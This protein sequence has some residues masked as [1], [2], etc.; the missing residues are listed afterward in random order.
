MP[1]EAQVGDAAFAVERELHA[2]LVAAERVVV[3][4][5]EVRRLQLRR[6][7]RPVVGPLVV[8]EDLLAVEVVHRDYTLV[9][10]LAKT[11]A[12]PAPTRPLKCGEGR[13]RDGPRRFAAVSARVP[14]SKSMGGRSDGE[15][16]QARP[17]PN[18]DGC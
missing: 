7:R 9:A 5:L 15:C 6:R 16:V 17:L 10:H 1:G 4:E 8:L 13:G 12:A 11:T 18:R 3:L 14:A 2:Q